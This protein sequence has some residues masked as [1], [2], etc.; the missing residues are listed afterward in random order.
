M[1]FDG[2]VALVTGGTSGIGE[3]TAIAFAREGAKVVIAGRRPA[4]GEAV[5]EQIRAM[6][7]DALFVQADV[8]REEAVQNLIT[9]IVGQYGRLDYAFNNAGIESPPAPLA[10]QSLE[11]FDTIM[12]INLRGVFLS[13]KYEIPAMLQ[14]GG[15]AIVNTSSVGGLVGFAGVGPYVATKHAVIG[16]TR[17]AALDYAKQGIRVNAVAPGSIV[18][19]MVERMTDRNPEVNAQIAA[20]HPMGRQGTPE[21]VAEAVIWLCSEKSSFVT[22]QWITM[23]GG[24]TATLNI[25]ASTALIDGVQP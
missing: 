24:L 19:P 20:M 15:G 8:S 22:G 17:V 11:H 21:D 3:T 16:L 18:T 1:L 12:A 9:R 7:G 14:T 2:K 4:E 25:C 13:L 6:N 10:E 5:V 23:D